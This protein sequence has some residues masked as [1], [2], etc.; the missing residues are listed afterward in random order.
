MEPCA[1]SP[2]VRLPMSSVTA[3]STW[4]LGSR[5]NPRSLLRL[6]CFPYAGGAAAAFRLW[7]GALAP[8]VEVCPV[9]LP[10]RGSRFREVP[11]RNVKELVSAAADG[12]RPMMDVPFALYGHSMGAV[13]AFELA[14]ELRRRSWPAP[15]LLA[16]SGRQAPPR[17]SPLPPFGH[18][19]DPEFLREVCGRYDNIPEE[20]L[21]EPELLQLV[22]PA[23]RADILLLETYPYTREL[24]LDCP[25]SCFGGEEDRHV[26]R[27]DLDAWAE[28]TR[29]GCKVRTF[30]GGHFFIDSAREAVWRALRED[31]RPWTTAATVA[32]ATQ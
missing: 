20:V 13:V 2:L 29:G 9:Q 17:P 27:A 8:E 7:V 24:P 18:L 28:H 22:L 23:L 5:P 1:A 10:G 12:L 32:T 6:L 21:A 3:A 14:R 19:P 31:L 26:S 11:F 16:V 4:V 25:I 30:P 15:V